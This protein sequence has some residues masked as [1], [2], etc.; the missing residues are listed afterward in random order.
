MTLTGIIGA[1]IHLVAVVL[2][3]ALMS[4]WK[5]R[6][7]LRFSIVLGALTTV[8]DLIIVMRW[9]VALGIPD[10]VFFFLG[11]ATFENFTNILHAIPMTAIC[12]KLAPP[13]M[14]SAVLGKCDFVCSLNSITSL[15]S[16]RSL[17][18]CA[19]LSLV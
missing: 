7:A 10:K 3:Q 6:T 4:T 2:Y 18:C 1:V 15:W 14:E 12:A 16:Y 11:N 17:L 8:V 9:N 13:G 5:Y 19:M